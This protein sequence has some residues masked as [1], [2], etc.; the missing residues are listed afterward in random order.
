MGILDKFI[1]TLLFNSK[2]KPGME[3]QYPVDAIHT[4]LRV[5]NESIDIARKSKNIETQLS[6]LGVAEDTLKR[7]KVEAGKFLID[8]NGFNQAEKEINRIRNAIQEGTPVEIEGMIDLD[9]TDPFASE[10][11]N[12]LKEATVLKKEKKYSEACKKLYEAYSANGSEN[13]MI[14]DRLRLPMYLQLA[15]RND[16]G[17]DELNRLLKVYNDEF[18]QP[19]IHNQMRIFLRKENNENASNP[20]RVSSQVEVERKSNIDFDYC[21]SNQDIYIGFEFHATLQLHIPLRVLMRH[22][23]IHSDMNSEPPKIAMNMSE[24]FWFPKLKP[25]SELGMKEMPEAFHTSDLGPVLPSNYLPFL[26]TLR[27]ILESNESIDDRVKMLIEY[28]MNVEWNDY[29]SKRGGM[30]SI[31]DKFFPRFIDTIPSLSVATV[32]ELFN[33]GLDTPN[34]IATTNDDVLLSISGIGKSKL[35]TIRDYCVKTT[36]NRNNTRVDKVTR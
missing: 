18:S 33:F 14:E 16:E 19:R 28:P 31:I 21:R 36:K 35:K 7:A 25:Y 27:E 10:S 9:I 34:A 6:R 1:N 13:L 3:T 26:V 15:G 20:V 2:T 32:D 5:I 17:W 11:R 8:V 12:F 22:G 29:V 30:G 23:E 4:S 24:G